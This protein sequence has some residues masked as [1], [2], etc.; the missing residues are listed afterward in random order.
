VTNDPTPTGIDAATTNVNEVLLLLGPPVGPRPHG[1]VSVDGEPPEAYLARHEAFQHARFL[2]DHTAAF[3]GITEPER[4]ARIATEYAAAAPVGTLD[5]I[6]AAT[7]EGRLRAKVARLE[8]EL[9]AARPADP[10]EPRFV[11]RAQD[12]LAVR[13]VR[14]YLGLC[15]ELGLDEQAAQVQAA[16]DE[17]EAWR[18]ANPDRVR[19]PD[20]THVPAQVTPTER[21]AAGGPATLP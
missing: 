21:K 17:I 10:T 20:H 1:P 2:E 18:A 15:L 9:A 4:A 16:L 19:L 3:L 6:R 8:A 11:I 12:T 5:E 13:A 7:P 14:A